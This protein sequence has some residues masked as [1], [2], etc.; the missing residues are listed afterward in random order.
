MTSDHVEVPHIDMDIVDDGT[1][2][3]FTFYEVDMHNIASPDTSDPGIEREIQ[4]KGLTA[5][6][7]TPA[8][9]EANIAGEHFH[10]PSDYTIGCGFNIGQFDAEK[11]KRHTIC[12]LTLRNGFTVV[13]VNEGPVS[14]ANFD[15]ELG[16][17]LARQKAIDQIWPL[18]GYELRT[19]LMGEQA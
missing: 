9:I 5:P 12:V 17:K 13:G 8:D 3:T 19:K 16:R 15:A 7:I 6:R 11:I 4:A 14:A 10:T 1:T 2:R 18:M